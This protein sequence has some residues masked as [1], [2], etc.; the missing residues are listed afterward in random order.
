MRFFEALLK[1][2]YGLQREPFLQD[3]GQP[4]QGPAHTEVAYSSTSANKRTREELLEGPTK[5]DRQPHTHPSYAEAQAAIEQ[6]A[7]CR[8]TSHVEKRA[9][10]E[11]RNLLA[12]LCFIP[13]SRLD[14]SD[15]LCHYSGDHIIKRLVFLGPKPE[16]RDEVCLPIPAQ[17]QEQPPTVWRQKEARGGNEE[18]GFCDFFAFLSLI[19]CA[20]TSASASASAAQ[21]SN[22]SLKDLRSSKSDMKENH[23]VNR[24]AQEYDD[25]DTTT[26]TSP[27][28]ITKKDDNNKDIKKDN[29]DMQD[30]NRKQSGAS[31][32]SSSSVALAPKMFFTELLLS[33]TLSKCFSR[34]LAS[35]DSP[36]ELTVGLIMLFYCMQYLDEDK[37]SSTPASSLLGRFVLA[38]P[39]PRTFLGIVTQQITFEH[40]QAVERLK[41]F[42]ER[43]FH[44]E[45]QRRDD[46]RLHESAIAVFKVRKY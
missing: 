8:I 16:Q 42:Q 45:S 13:Q 11:A 12:A 35:A 34:I 30:R 38:S 32:L 39:V 43:C 28:N 23:T 3:V 6:Q 9:I 4:I 19:L 18:A 24:I 10:R 1:F 31:P 25:E 20:A 22:H 17:E 37:N 29:K 33:L 41:I 26:P 44:L 21:P 5:S 7:D 40:Q 36:K 2:T 14:L 15:L 27:T 46:R